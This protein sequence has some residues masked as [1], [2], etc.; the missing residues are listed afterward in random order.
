MGVQNI[1]F[2]LFL[3]FFDWKKNAFLSSF[4]VLFVKINS[5][6]PTSWP[7]SICILNKVEIYAKNGSCFYQLAWEKL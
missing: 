1:F 7:Q 2:L 4:N 6:A 5:N 3:D